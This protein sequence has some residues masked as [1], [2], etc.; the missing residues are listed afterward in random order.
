MPARFDLW[1]LGLD[2]WLDITV[3]LFVEFDDVPVYWPIKLVTPRALSLKCLL[4]DW[5]DFFFEPPP[6]DCWCAAVAGCRLKPLELTGLTTW[7]R[8]AG[9]A[10]PVA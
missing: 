7:A 4:D 9:W 5:I 6:W 10:G 1:I 3:V 8:S 2:F